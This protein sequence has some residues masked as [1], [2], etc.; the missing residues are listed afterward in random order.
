MNRTL[1]TVLGALLLAGATA[2]H[3]QTPPA[4]AGKQ[5]PRAHQMRDCSKAPDPKA[6][7]ERRQKMRSAHDEAKKA[8]DGKAGPERRDCMRKS[9]CAKSADPAKCEARDK[10][11]ANRKAKRDAAK[12]AKK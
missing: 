11:R 5:K 9:M 3:A 10:E 4:D 2:L 7:E 8:C 1:S 12:D 6:C